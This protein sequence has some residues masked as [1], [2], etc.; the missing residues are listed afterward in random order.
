MMDLSLYH[1]I[2]NKVENRITGGLGMM[3]ESKEWSEN[4]MTGEILDGVRECKIEYE[5]SSVKLVI[6]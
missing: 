2:G 4:S 6:D 3:Y 5:N 1:M